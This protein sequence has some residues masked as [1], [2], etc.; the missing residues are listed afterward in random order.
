MQGHILSTSVDALRTPKTTLVLSLQNFA[1]MRKLK[2][3]NS[4]MKKGFWNTYQQKM[5]GEKKK[6]KKASYFYIWFGF[7]YV[8]KM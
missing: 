7:Q 1:K 3:K 5:K 8:A 4:Q 2:L 6:A